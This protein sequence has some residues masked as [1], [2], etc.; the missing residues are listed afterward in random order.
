MSM[1]FKTL[2]FLVALYFLSR[3][4]SRMLMPES[5]RKRSS[6]TFRTYNMNNRAPRQPRKKNIDRIEEAE[7]E[8]I[9]EQESSKPESS[10]E[11]KHEL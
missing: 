5:A 3:F 8:E 4:I 2:I 7:F 1:L 6:F 11:D 10:K 9:P